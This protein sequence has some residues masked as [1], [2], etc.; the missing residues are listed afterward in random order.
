MNEIVRHYRANDD[1][2]CQGCNVGYGDQDPQIGVRG[3][4]EPLYCM[5]CKTNLIDAGYAYYPEDVIIAEV[6]AERSRQDGLWKQQNHPSVGGDIS[7]YE[8]PT[9]QRAKELCE[10]TFKA[11]N[12]TW[13]HIILEEFVEAV[14]AK[15]ETHRREEL[16]QLTACCLAWIECLD[17]RNV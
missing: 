15:D 1:W 2:F 17:R 3:L 8:L 13:A 10:D 14:N 11:G 12:G 9:E 5:V 7:R 6:L 16:V 4:R